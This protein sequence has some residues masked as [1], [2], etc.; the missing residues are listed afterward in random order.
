MHAAE[1]DAA[2]TET[3]L[4]VVNISELGRHRLAVPAPLRISIEQQSGHLGAIR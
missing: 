1:K 4:S 3:V 2:Q